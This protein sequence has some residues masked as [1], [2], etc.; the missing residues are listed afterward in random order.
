MSWA[1]DKVSVFD[2]IP[3]VI[4][5]K[6]T[7]TFTEEQASLINKEIPIPLTPEQIN[8]ICDSLI[9]APKQNECQ[10]KVLENHKNRIRL[11]LQDIKIKPSRYEEIKT[12]IISNFYKSLIAPG[13]SAGTNAAQ[14]IS[15]PTTQQ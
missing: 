10:D 14:N 2:C 12:I 11:E 7:R 6:N 5:S 3:D 15:E 4:T 9:L 1:D 8:D 13:E